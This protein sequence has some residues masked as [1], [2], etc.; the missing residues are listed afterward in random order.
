MRAI[1][2]FI[3]VILAAADCRLDAATSG[4]VYYVHSVLSARFN[5]FCVFTLYLFSCSVQLNVEN[6]TVVP[7]EWHLS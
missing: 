6:A 2:Q 4:A 1:Q 5:V 3:I 7:E